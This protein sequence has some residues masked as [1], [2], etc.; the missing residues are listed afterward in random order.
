MLLTTCVIKKSTIGYITYYIQLICIIVISSFWSYRV[1]R[2]LDFTIHDFHNKQYK[3]VI[4]EILS[5]YI[6]TGLLAI[7]SILSL[8]F[9][10]TYSNELK[11]EEVKEREERRSELE[12]DTDTDVDSYNHRKL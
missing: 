12:D 11:F 6:F 4:I 5:D 8:L 10:L 3:K 9:L 1:I 2:G 7:F